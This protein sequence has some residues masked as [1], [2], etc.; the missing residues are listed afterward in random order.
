MGEPQP[1]T[2][3]ERFGRSLRLRRSEDFRRVQRRG[4]RRK[5]R[6]L[7]LVWLPATRELPRFGLAV[8]KKVGNAVTRN[9]V[10]RWIREAIR[11]NRHGLTGLDA[12]LIARPG[13]GASTFPVVQAEVVELFDAI[14][15]STR[16]GGAA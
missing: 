3:R 9:R 2:R 13:A 7:V 15:S 14:R 11:R 6:H 8:S 4:Q 16:P 5:T 1:G 10:K 12:V